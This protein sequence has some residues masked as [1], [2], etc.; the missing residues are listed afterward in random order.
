MIILASLGEIRGLK[1]LHTTRTLSS[2]MIVKVNI[3]TQ[4]K[5]LVEWHKDLAG[6]FIER[7]R[8]IIVDECSRKGDRQNP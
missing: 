3:D 2:V 8:E 4:K 6:Q 7:P 1:G 5:H